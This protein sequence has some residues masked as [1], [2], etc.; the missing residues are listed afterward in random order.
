VVNSDASRAKP[1][2]GEPWPDRDVWVP[3]MIL[4]GL[5][6]VIAAVVSPVA[7]SS[8]A[9]WWSIALGGLAQPRLQALPSHTLPGSYIEWRR[10]LMRIHRILHGMKLP[11][12]FLAWYVMSDI[13]L[14]LALDRGPHAEWLVPWMMLHVAVNPLLACIVAV[15]T[16]AHAARARQRR[17]IAG[18]ILLVPVLVGIAYL[19]FALDFRLLAWLGLN[20]RGA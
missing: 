19:G 4:W 18:T 6:G 20:V 12:I 2:A 5:G 13:G 11:L 1:E 16:V 3:V 14:P 9:V 17:Q 15:A 10:R 8:N 7:Y